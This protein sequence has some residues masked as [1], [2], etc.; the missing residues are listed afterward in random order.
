MATTD[1]YPPSRLIRRRLERYPNAALWGFPVDR[2]R[3]LAD[4][5]KT[6]PPNIDSEEYMSLLGD[7]VIRVLSE[8][9]AKCNEI[10]YSPTTSTKQVYSKGARTGEK[11]VVALVKCTRSEDKF[12]PPPDKV[13]EL[14][15]VFAAQ[16][17]TEEP[18]WFIA[19]D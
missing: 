11:T 5:K 6:A 8:L 16:G 12:L 10:W 2:K 1:K 4:F 9:D 3:M 7:H 15:K 17:F 19:A 13:E 18:G 14:K